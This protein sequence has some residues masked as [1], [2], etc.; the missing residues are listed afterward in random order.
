MSYFVHF[1]LKSH[2][3]FLNFVLNKED[4]R[5]NIKNW[6]KSNS[7]GGVSS[8][9]VHD[10]LESM[11]FRA[12]KGQAKLEQKRSRHELNRYPNH[13]NTRELGNSR[14]LESA[15]ADGDDECEAKRNYLK[16]SRITSSDSKASEDEKDDARPTS[17]KDDH[18]QLIREAASLVLPKTRSQR[19]ERA[20]PI[21]EA[22]GQ[23][24]TSKREDLV[25][26]AWSVATSHSGSK[27]SKSIR[28]NKSKESHEIEGYESNNS[29]DSLISPVFPKAAAV[30]LFPPIRL[31][32]LHKTVPVKHDTGTQEIIKK[33]SYATNEIKQVL[34]VW[35]EGGNQDEV[36]LHE[37]SEAKVRKQSKFGQRIYPSNSQ[38][39]IQHTKTKSKEALYPKSNIDAQAPNTQIQDP[40]PQIDQVQASESCI[41]SQNPTKTRLKLFKRENL[42]LC[43]LFLFILIVLIIAGLTII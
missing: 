35:G 33:E 23:P 12:E 6:R 7:F 39:S 24:R 11:S 26:G 37:P 34:T 3:I 1:V 27:Q 14:G 30:G 8:K 15:D 2:Y 21:S 42:F 13:L 19:H 38:S 28:L 20:K 17:N 25:D 22:D 10:Q 40:K 29:S 18:L 31:S 36:R 4:T 32:H 16:N 41:P 9:T 43:A 5:R